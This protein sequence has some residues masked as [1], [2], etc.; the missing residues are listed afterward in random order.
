MH[1]ERPR[2]FQELFVKLSRRE[3][4]PQ[5]HEEFWALK[6]VS[7]DVAPGDALGLIGAN[8]AGKSTALKL[9][10]RII[11]PTSGRVQING[12][13][14]ALLELGAGFHP[15]LTGRENVY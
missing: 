10:S 1:R 3:S 7:F 13:I 4:G 14:G 5:R 9:I 6:D 8:G 11:A 2:S 12:R 15:D